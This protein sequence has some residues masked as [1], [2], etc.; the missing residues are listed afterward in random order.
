[1]WKVISFYVIVIAGLALLVASV[2]IAPDRPLTLLAFI[3]L[4]TLWSVWLV[5]AY[6]AWIRSL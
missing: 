2:F 6:W 1:M 3:P 5:R 4:L